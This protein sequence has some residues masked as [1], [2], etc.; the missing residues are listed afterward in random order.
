MDGTFPASPVMREVEELLAEE[1]FA[2]TF[3]PLEI[4]GA[5]PVHP[6]RSGR[7]DPQLA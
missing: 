5:P 1:G 3:A 4:G 7:A 2:Q 6:A